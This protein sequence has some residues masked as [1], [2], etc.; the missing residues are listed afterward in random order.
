MSSI[1]NFILTL[2]IAVIFAS[3]QTSTSGEQSHDEN[4]AI[5]LNQGKKWVVVPEMMHII[6]SME[7]DI[8]SFSGSSLEEHGALGTKLQDN[9]NTLTSNCTM[10]GQG[11]DELHKWLLPFLDSVKEYTKSKNTAEA[12]RSY[13]QIKTSYNTVN[14]YF[15]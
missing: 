2:F 9:L 8:N 1:S 7:S 4:S 5:V 13:A 3:C 11:H 14:R 10:K 15:E 6:R 12:T